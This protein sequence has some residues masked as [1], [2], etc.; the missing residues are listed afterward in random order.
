[1]ALGELQ[2]QKQSECSSSQTKE[3]QQQFT[4][5]G[6]AGQSSGSNEHG[7]DNSWLQFIADDVWCSKT[8]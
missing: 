5:L 1:V 6:D 7:K 8:K 2:K 4:N 3:K